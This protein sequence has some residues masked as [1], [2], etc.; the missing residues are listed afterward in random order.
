MSALKLYTYYRSSAAYRVRI[1]LNLKRL[2]YEAHCVDLVRDGGEHRRPEY[3]ALNPQGLVPTLIDG[4][5]VL[6]QSLAILEY[7]EERYPEPPILPQRPE[8]RAFARAIADIVACD[9]HPLNNLRVLNYLKNCLG[10][11]DESYVIWYRYWIYEGFRAIEEM[12]EKYGAEG[13]FCCGDGPTV[14]DICLI[15]QVFNALRYE[16][17]LSYY[18][19]VKAIYKNC[20]AMDAF[21]RAAPENQP[22][23]KPQPQPSTE[24]RESP[25]PA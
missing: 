3:Q 21:R 10:K 13:R 5:T 15:P 17:D 9:I 11:N 23:C 20:L 24:N 1:A 2:D 14:A 8:E 19:R 22:D 25:A 12:L 7:L 18:P 4:D 6:I 16:C